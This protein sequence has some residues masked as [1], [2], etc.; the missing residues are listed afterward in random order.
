MGMRGSDA[1]AP[2]DLVTHY[3]EIID[4]LIKQGRVV[5]SRV[6]FARAGV[7]VA[8]KAGSPK[9]DISTPEAFRRAMLA[10]KSI[11]YARTGA[12]GII[13]AKLIGWLCR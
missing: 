9:P 11:A 13:A 8:V 4:D 7:G 6:D 5:G 3:P 12:S 10:A 1:N 2:A